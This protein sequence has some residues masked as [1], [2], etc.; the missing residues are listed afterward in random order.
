MKEIVGSMIVLAQSTVLSG[1]M[2]RMVADEALPDSGS[3]ASA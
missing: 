2:P 3:M 1:A